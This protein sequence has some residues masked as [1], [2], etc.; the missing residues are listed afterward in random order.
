MDTRRGWVDLLLLLESSLIELSFVT[1]VVMNTV[2]I[3]A[4]YVLNR[5]IGSLFEIMVLLSVATYWLGIATAERSR[6]HLG[7]NF[8]TSKLTGLPRHVCEI[9][10]LVVIACF[11]L[12][13]AY[14]AAGVALSQYLSG[15]VSG[16][17]AMP[18]WLFTTFIPV[19]CMLMLL[20][21]LKNATAP[22]K[23]AA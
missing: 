23:D 20:R 18:L 9:L 19:G 22:V 21:V 8:V 15:A 11:L 17:V 5:S 16:T 6:S 2:N 13:A 4:R 3:F 14:S 7:M 10:R 1:Q 12:A